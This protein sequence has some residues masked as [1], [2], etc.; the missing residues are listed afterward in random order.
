MKILL[1]WR[2]LGVLGARIF[3]SPAAHNSSWQVHVLL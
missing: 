1:T 3:I 2:T